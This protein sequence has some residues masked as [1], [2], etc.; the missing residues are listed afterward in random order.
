MRNGEAK[1]LEKE[2]E[3]NK[4]ISKQTNKQPNNVKDDTYV[5]IRQPL[6]RSEPLPRRRLIKFT[7]ILLGKRQ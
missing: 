2:H 1:C 4:H 7:C 6:H 3:T 5:A